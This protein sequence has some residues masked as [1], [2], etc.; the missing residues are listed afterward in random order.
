MDMYSAFYKS[1]E[2][3]RSVVPFPLKAC[4]HMLLGFVRD[5]QLRG[6]IQRWHE[7]KG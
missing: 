6:D 1:M 7:L 4:Q 3:S 2:L 5:L